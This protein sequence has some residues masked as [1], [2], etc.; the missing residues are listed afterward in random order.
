VTIP[1]NAIG[2]AQIAPGAVQSSDIL[3][4]TV[5]LADLNTS[6]VDARYVLKNGDTMTGALRAPSLV[7][8]LLT[9]STGL[10]SLR[11]L[12]DLE[13]HLGKGGGGAS[14]FKVLNNSGS[15]LFSLAESGQARV[16]GNAFIGGVLGVGTTAPD[17]NAIAQFDLPSSVAVPHVRIKS[18]LGNNGFGLQ[19]ANPNA[20][21]FVGPNMGNW[22]DDRFCLLSDSSNRGLI[23]GTNGN[24]AIDSVSASAPF[25]TLTIDGTIGFPSVSTP[26]MYVYPSGTA[27]AE[28]PLIVHS[29]AFPGYGLYYRDDGDR[30]V[31]KSSAGDPSPSLVVDLD[32]NWV[33][34]DADLPK[35]GYALSV[36]GKIV[37]EDMLIQDSTLWGDYVFEENYALKP[38]EELETQIKAHKHLPGIP[39][40]T[41][42]AQDGIVIGDMQKRMMVKIEELTL[43]V[44]EQHKKLAAQEARISQL[45]VQ[46]RQQEDQ[47]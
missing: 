9:N 26:A 18:S 40:A 24:V 16:L 20:T 22:N 21:W 12:S 39:T 43:Y 7:T 10:L 38:L 37:C 15:N 13:L 28:K 36:N 2:S 4:G 23:I 5:G 30:F 17:P 33:T 46:L 3:D 31:M 32:S 11:A 1:G 8:S 44:I 35:P 27:N 14:A 47:R 29:P 45:E 41:E 6:S 34:I 42:I 25:A 19:F